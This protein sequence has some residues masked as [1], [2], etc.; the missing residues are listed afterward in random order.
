M[1]FR[2]VLEMLQEKDVIDTLENEVEEGLFSFT[3]VGIICQNNNT[4]TLE[5]EKRNISNVNFISFNDVFEE[6][7][8]ERFTKKVLV[9]D[10][11]IKNANKNI[12]K[13]KDMTDCKI[14]IY[15]SKETNI[16]N[17]S[18]DKRIE[19]NKN[20][21]VSQS[22]G[23]S[24]R[25]SQLNKEGRRLNDDSCSS[26]KV[27]TEAMLDII[28][29]AKSL[30]EPLGAKIEQVKSMSLYDCQEYFHQVGGPKPN[31]ENKKV[32]MKPDGGIL[33]M[34]HKDKR[35]P[36][37]ITEDKV[38]GTNDLRHEE[39]KS[40]QATGNAIERAAKNIRSAEMLFSNLDIFPYVIFAS[41]C[42]FHSSETIAKR[43]EA[44]NMGFPNHYVE[45]SPN[46][47]E[48][49]ISKNI[50]NII[51]SI[52]IQKKCGSRCIVSAFVKAHKWDEMKH[53][54]STWKK[55]EIVKI[56]EQV[57]RLVFDSIS[58]SLM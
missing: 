37:L 55:Q 40:H 22:E 36:I 49:E 18:D 8:E 50:D 11:K 34:T 43:I 35:I 27:L 41:G 5:F 31:P 28:T 42:D 19:M 21:Q 56:C 2:N 12:S 17:M 23:L 53:G 16:N 39:Q 25:L 48:E 26:E 45:I 58:P 47:K 20:S 7:I 46:I 30:F 4:F 44:F 29:F 32:Y 3:N 57:I 14:I 52:D 24:K 33:I 38:Q 6:I 10:N 9:V 15:S 1:Y 54:S 13:I 51:T